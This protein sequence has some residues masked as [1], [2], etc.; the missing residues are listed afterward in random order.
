VPHRVLV[1]DDEPDIRMLLRLQLR[2]FD[3]DVVEA[4]DG[5]QALDVARAERPDAC[6][7]DHRMPGR[8]GAD[9]AVELHAER[10][11]LPIVVF[12]AFLDPALEERVRAS[13]ITTVAKAD[14]AGLL[15]WLREHLPA[16][17]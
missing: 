5:A 14:I 13:G 6:I 10:P 1:A 9:V 2:V 17:A 7:L 12:S 15:G 8:L 11:E 16:K 3:V 4:Q